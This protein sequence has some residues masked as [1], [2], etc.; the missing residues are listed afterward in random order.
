LAAEHLKSIGVDVVHDLPGSAATFRIIM[1][2][3]SRI[4]CAA[5][6]RSI[7][8]RAGSAWR[9]K[10][11]RFA[12]AGNGALTFGVTSAMVFLPQPGRLSSPDLQ[13]LFTPASYAQGVFRNWSASPA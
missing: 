2:S 10:I 4:G 7:S 9:A 8:S 3:A 12:T 13:L 5:R 1:S 11:A 6:K